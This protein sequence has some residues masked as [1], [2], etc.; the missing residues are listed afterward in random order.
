MSPIFEPG[1]SD[2]D[3]LIEVWETS[4]RATHDFLQESDIRW[5]RPQVRNEYF[6][7]VRL[8]AFRNEDGKIQ[9]FIGVAEGKIE[10]LFIAPTA[11]GQGIGKKLLQYAVTILGATELDV[12][13]QN[14]QAV[15]FYLHQGFEVVGR[16]PLDGMGKPFPLLH[17]KLSA[18]K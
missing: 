18:V 9:G 11:R 7:A 5:L 2:F 14:P 3:E 1:K 4:V 17:M 15:G 6:Y 8:Y 13:E 10:M 16:S 12:N